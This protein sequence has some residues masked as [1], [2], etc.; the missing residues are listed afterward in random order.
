MDFGPLIKPL[1]TSYTSFMK[2]ALVVSGVFELL[3]DVQVAELRYCSSCYIFRPH[4]SDREE[5]YSHLHSHPDQTE[6][7][8][9]QK[10]LLGNFS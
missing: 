2:S 10:L 7:V 9:Q 8:T 3:A 6:T 1:V 4:R 5:S